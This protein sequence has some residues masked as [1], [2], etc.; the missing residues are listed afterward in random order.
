VPRSAE[1]LVFSKAMPSRL[2]SRSLSM[3]ASSRNAVEVGAWAH[4]CLGVPSLRCKGASLDWRCD[5]GNL[6]PT[7]SRA[8]CRCVLKGQKITAQQHLAQSSFTW[9]IKQTFIHEQ[10]D[11]QLTPQIDRAIAPEDHFHPCM[12]SRLVRPGAHGVQKHELLKL[13]ARFVSL[14]SAHP[15]SAAAFFHTHIRTLQTGGHC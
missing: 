15:W 5:G 10:L 6:L 11:T 1:R 2:T 4:V 7:A 9:H 14:S 13:D 12:S 3:R 8:K